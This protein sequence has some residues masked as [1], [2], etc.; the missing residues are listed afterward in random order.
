[1]RN[2]YKSIIPVPSYRILQELESW[3]WLHLGGSDK[4]QPSVDSARISQV[5]F[6]PPEHDSR[7]LGYGGQAFDL[8]H[9]GGQAII[10]SYM[11]MT[12][13]LTV[14][15]KTRTVVL[16]DRTV[17]FKRCTIVFK[18]CTFVLNTG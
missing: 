16:T 5:Q 13:G 7:T 6:K 4:T 15:L 11:V 12:K 9:K 10:P 18:R 1:M 3:V 17:V 8:T 2:K 14:M